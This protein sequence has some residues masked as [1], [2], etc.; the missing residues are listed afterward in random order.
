M[1]PVNQIDDERRADRGAPVRQRREHH[2]AVARDDVAGDMGG[3]GERA[4]RVERPPAA[5]L[6]EDFREQPG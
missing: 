3:D 4:D 2:G 1:I 5:R 6:P